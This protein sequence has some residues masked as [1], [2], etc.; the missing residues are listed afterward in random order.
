MTCTILDVINGGSL[1]LLV[2]DT[3]G[4][5]VDQ[6]VEPRQMADIVV[7]EGLSHPAELRWREIELADD[8]LTVAFV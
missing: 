3:G 8:G 6:P 2:V 1:W 7:G 4:R 5:I